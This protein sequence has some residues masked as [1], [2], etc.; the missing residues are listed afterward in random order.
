MCGD[1]EE[2]NGP[3]EVSYARFL[4]AARALL[5]RQRAQSHAAA[6][7]FAYLDKLFADVLDRAVRDAEAAPPEARYE[8]LAAQPLVFARLAGLMAGHLA[9]EEDPLRKVLEALMHGYAEADTIAHGHDHD[10]DHHGH[11]HH[12]D[13]GEH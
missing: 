13:S 4:L 5:A 6:S 8:R 10:H 2:D 11:S 12:H 3:E 7:Q 1:L 9:I